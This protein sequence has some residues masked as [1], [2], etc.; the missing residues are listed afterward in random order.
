MNYE[1]HSIR[2]NLLFI[3]RLLRRF[4]SPHNENAAG[5]TLIEVL[6]ALGIISIIATALGAVVV[7]SMSN[8][9][10]SKNQNQALDYARE[11]MEIVRRLRDEDIVGFRSY[12]NTFCLG[13][14]AGS[15]GADCVSP[16]IDNFFLRKVT[17]AQSGCTANVASVV[18]TV[19]WANGKC[20]AGNT[21]CRVTRLDSCLSVVNPVSAL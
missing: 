2:R 12:N 19:S 6:V 20:T 15:L 5:Q 4:K 7:D 16:N 21:F 18:V 17:V 8:A 14:G 11:G 13:K 1:S 9:Q 10:L 3:T